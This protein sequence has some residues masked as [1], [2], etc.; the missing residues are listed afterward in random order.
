VSEH[1]ELGR[2]LR[3]AD[4]GRYR[5]LRIAER[6]LQCFQLGLHGA[7]GEA[8]QEMRDPLSRR[9]R[10]VGSRE[11]VVDV[12][13]AEPCHR[14]RQLRIVLLLARVKARI[15]EHADVAGKHG[16]DRA[17]GF[18]P[19]AIF[20]KSDGATRQAVDRKHQLRRRHVRPLLALWPAEVRQQKHDGASVAEL[21]HGRKHRSKPRV[22]GHL[23]AVHR[24]IQVDSNEHLLAGQIFGQVV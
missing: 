8:R 12:V 7:A 16:R 23:R 11:G 3:P 4:Y 14:L 13:I 18:G 9:M 1:G 17:L 21:E 6:L 24:D 20:D 19:A 5:P 15:L 2:D 10:A 22:V